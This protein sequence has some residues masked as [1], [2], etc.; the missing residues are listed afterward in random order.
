[1]YTS[2]N[3]KCT[4]K[5]FICKYDFIYLFFFFFELLTK[6][7][8]LKKNSRYL[9]VPKNDD[10][11]H[12]LERCRKG[13]FHLGV[14]QEFWSWR[15]TS[16]PG[17][18]ILRVMILEIED[19]LGFFQFSF[20]GHPSKKSFLFLDFRNLCSLTQMFDWVLLHIAV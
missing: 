3:S 20:L 17:V 15:E 11:L 1:M 2:S 10:P 8:K 19:C 12:C 18:K 9:Q 13:V 4:I 7:S 16:T 14:T 6:I 5:I